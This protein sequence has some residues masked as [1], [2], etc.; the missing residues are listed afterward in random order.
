MEKTYYLSQFK[1]GTIV[2]SV[3]DG[4]CEDFRI[5]ENILSKYALPATFNII[6][7]NIGREINLSKDQLSILYNDS[8]IEIAAHGSTHKNDDEDILMGIET[9]RDWLGIT[10]KLIGFASPGSKMKNDFIKDNA[11]HLRSLGLLYVRTDKNPGLSKRHLDIQNEL[12]KNGASEYVIKNIPQ[13][14]YSFNNMC[15]NSAVVYNQTNLDDLKKLVD[16]AAQEKACIVFMFHKIKKIGE[17]NYDSVWCY[18]Y[19]KF[20]EFARHL[21]QKR[22]EGMIDILTNKQAFLIGSHLE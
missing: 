17:L 8:S 22:D 6:S 5:Y 12:L 16:I 4:N 20:E 10:E 3:D 1:K 19:T 9:L 2:I 18:D 11:Q 15:V 14:T 21:A 7:G 13:L